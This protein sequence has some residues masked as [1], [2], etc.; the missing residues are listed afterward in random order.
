M[1]LK[2]TNL[3]ENSSDLSDF[4]A[5]ER[6]W[7]RPRRSQGDRYHGDGKSIK[8]ESDFPSIFAGFFHRSR[9]EFVLARPNGT[10]PGPGMS[11]PGRQ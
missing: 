11:P 10:A 6:R 8:I 4:R 1:A 9:R 3:G 7:V 2:C 5:V